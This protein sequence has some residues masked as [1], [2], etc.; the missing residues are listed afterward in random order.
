MVREAVPDRHHES[1]LREYTG[2]QFK[3]E[4]GPSSATQSYPTSP[5]DLLSHL[6][7]AVGREN[8]KFIRLGAYVLVVMVGWY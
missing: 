8:N 1:Q 6:S 2:T 3:D 7:I 5:T 4:D